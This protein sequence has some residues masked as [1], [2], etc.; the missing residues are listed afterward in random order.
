MNRIQPL[1]HLV[2]HWVCLLGIATSWAQE[3]EIEELR[4]Q[5]R[6]SEDFEQFPEGSE[7]A[8]WEEGSWA[9][10]LS[11]GVGSIQ[12][13]I[14]GEAAS[15]QLVVTGGTFDWASPWV[16]VDRVRLAKVKMTVT[17]VLNADDEFFGNGV[18]L[19]AET[20]H[21]KQALG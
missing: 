18:T 7:M 14:E 4:P 2:G 19:Y 3:P 9:D 13:T 21:N 1:F 10:S 15:K 8:P 11:S 6:F 12:S 17:A 16:P 5:I 20:R